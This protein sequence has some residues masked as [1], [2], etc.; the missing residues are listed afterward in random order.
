MGTGRRGLTGIAVAAAVVAGAAVAVPTAGAQPGGTAAAGTVNCPTVRAKVERLEGRVNPNA[1]AFM[2]RQIAFGEIPTGTPPAVGDVSHPRVRAYL[3]IFDPEASLWEAGAKA[4]RGH[5]A[6]G[7]SIVNSLRLAPSLGYR[8]TDVVADGSTVMFGQW[9]EVTLRGRTIGYP[10]IA[11]NVLGDEGRT[12]QARR[13]YDRAV[14]FQDTLPEDAPAPLFAGV[15]DSGEAHPGQ[16][17]ARFRV[18]EAPARLAAWNGEDTE[19]LL[20][21][22]AGARLMGPGLRAPLTTDAGKR[23]YLE[24]LFGSGTFRLKAGQVAVGTTTTYVEWHGTVSNAH[25]TDVPFGI[26]ERFGPD[27]AWE[28]YF[29]TLPLVLEQDAVRVLFQKLAAS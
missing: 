15:A 29:D 6:I 14:L 10:Q 27:G 24:R 4:Q 12:I 22:S 5:T 3:D 16:E 28:L 25:G 19:A 26:V 11:R 21:R 7:T 20:A 8:G 9:N 23:A 2:E 18:G 13:Y 17:P 1:C